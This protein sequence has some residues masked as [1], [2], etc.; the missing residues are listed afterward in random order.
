MLH[1]LSVASFP[2]RLFVYFLALLF[3][4]VRLSGL[5]CSAFI[6]AFCSFPYLCFLS[7]SALEG[8]GVLT[9]QSSFIAASAFS[10]PNAG[11]HDN[12]SPCVWAP[13]SSSSNARSHTESRSKADVTTSSG[14]WCVSHIP[15]RWHFRPSPK[16]SR[17]PHAWEM[18]ESC[19]EV[20]E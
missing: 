18:Q 16:R 8:R 9:F 12:Y 7:M 17:M 13:V 10:G 2:F 20:P 4:S 15:F 11:A 5:F 1:F 3:W 14:R 6:S 19:V